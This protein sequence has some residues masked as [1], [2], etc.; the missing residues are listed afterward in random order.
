MVAAVKTTNSVVAMLTSALAN[1]AR[2]GAKGIP[3][4]RAATQNPTLISS[5]N[6]RGYRQQ[7]ADEQERD[8][9]EIDHQRPHGNLP[10]GKGLCQ[11]LADRKPEAQPERVQ[12]HEEHSKPVDQDA[13]TGLSCHIAPFSRA[14]DPPGWTQSLTISNPTSGSSRHSQARPLQPLRHDVR[15]ERTRP[16]GHGRRSGQQ[17][18]LDVHGVLRYAGQRHARGR[19]RPAGRIARRGRTPSEEGGSGRAGCGRTGPAVRLSACGGS[20]SPSNATPL[21]RGVARSQHGS[22]LLSSRRLSGQARTPAAPTLPN[23]RRPSGQPAVVSMSRR[24]WSSP[25]AV[26]EWDKRSGRESE[27]FENCPLR[28]KSRRIAA[29]FWINHAVRFVRRVRKIRWTGSSRSAREPAQV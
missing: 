2:R 4:L 29:P 6:G 26:R 15:S 24:S 14:D 8:D 20:H 10:M 11:Q 25:R 23:S 22:C 17:F 5:R 21:R 12:D 16:P 9:D 1:R 28:P 7:I 27:R 13:L 18:G 19:R 3:A